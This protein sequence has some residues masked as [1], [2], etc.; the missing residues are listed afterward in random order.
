M[1]MGLHLDANT[2]VLAKPSSENPSESAVTLNAKGK[3]RSTSFNLKP[4]QFFKVTRKDVCLPEID[5]SD[6]VHT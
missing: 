1:A 6:G 3:V 5:E 4:L 2:K